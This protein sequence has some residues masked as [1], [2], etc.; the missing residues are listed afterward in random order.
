MILYEEPVLR[1]GN[2]IINVYGF[3]LSDIPKPNSRATSNEI[4]FPIFLTE[5]IKAIKLFSK[6][7]SH[8][9]IKEFEISLE[10]LLHD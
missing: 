4:H 3:F 1:R 6:I 2:E 7:R 8:Y 9:D 5:K 10:K